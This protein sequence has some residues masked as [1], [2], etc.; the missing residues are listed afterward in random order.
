MANSFVDIE[1]PKLYF[2]V[3]FHSNTPRESADFPLSYGAMALPND[4][5][6]ALGFVTATNDLHTFGNA[7]A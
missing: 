4:H 6:P 1:D 5:R 3:N 2:E 7:R